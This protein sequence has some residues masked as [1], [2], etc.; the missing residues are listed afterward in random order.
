MKKRLVQIFKNYP[1]LV[2]A[3]GHDH[4]LQYIRKA[5]QHYIVSGSGSKVTYVHKGK[6][7][8]FTHAHKGFFRLN[9][10]RKGDVWL[11]AWEPEEDGSPRL[12]YRSHIVWGE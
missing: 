1:N 5:S 11:E 7:A 2:Y 8:A 4:N 10:F 3:A 12:A 9:Y 6:G